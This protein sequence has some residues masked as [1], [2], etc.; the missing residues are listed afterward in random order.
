MYCIDHEI[1]NLCSQCIRNEHISCRMTPMDVFQEIDSCLSKEILSEKKDF[2]RILKNRKREIFKKIDKEFTDLYD[3]GNGV[4]ND[5]EKRL[6]HILLENLNKN[7]LEVIRKNKLKIIL[8]E[9][10]FEHGVCIS[11]DDSNDF[12]RIKKPDFK[13][14][15]T[16][17]GLAFQEIRIERWESIPPSNL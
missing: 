10:K 7:K 2:E 6:K 15:A 1:P 17:F 11:A 3:F 9:I 16:S 12:Q 8:N 5:N 4:I 13:N 14:D